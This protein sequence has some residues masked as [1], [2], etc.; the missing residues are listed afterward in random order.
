MRA[1]GASELKNFGIHYILK[2]LFLSIFCRYI[3][4]MVPNFISGAGPPPPKPPGPVLTGIVAYNFSFVAIWHQ[5]LNF[6]EDVLILWPCF[7]GNVI[8]KIGHF[9]LKTHN[10]VDPKSF[11]FL[12]LGRVSA[13]LWKMKTAW[14]KRSIHYITMQCYNSGK[15]RTKFPPYLLNRDLWYK[16]GTFDNDS[17]SEKKWL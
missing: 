4:R 1:S 12:P 3:E 6:D 13:L 15:L 17:A 9:F 11:G 8:F 16:R 10:D 14:I 2:L 5:Y 7:L